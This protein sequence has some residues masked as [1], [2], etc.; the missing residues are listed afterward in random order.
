MMG[1][2]FLHFK[3]ISGLGNQ[4]VGV[5]EV[6]GERL[7]GIAHYLPWLRMPCAGDVHAHISARTVAQA[8][9]VLATQ[10]QTGAVKGCSFPLSLE[11]VGAVESADPP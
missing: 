7:H 8:F 11:A 1:M 6:D 5:E 10:E 2:V 9:T 4:C 3:E